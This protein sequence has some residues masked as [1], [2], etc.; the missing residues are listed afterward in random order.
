MIGKDRKAQDFNPHRS[1]QKLKPLADPFAAMFVVL[2][3]DGIITAQETSPHT[4]IDA[5]HDVDLI[6]RT[7]FST[8]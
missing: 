2:S 6:N 1:G 3:R 7:T 8:A 5:V 4:A